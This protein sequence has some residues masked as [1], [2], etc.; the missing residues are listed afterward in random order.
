M[1]PVHRDGDEYEGAQVEQNVQHDD[2]QDAAAEHVDDGEHQPDR[3][4]AGDTDPALVAVQQ[5]E[6]LGALYALD[7]V[8]VGGLGGRL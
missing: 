2:E 1:H 8:T 4:G 6:A 7:E 5:A 3:G